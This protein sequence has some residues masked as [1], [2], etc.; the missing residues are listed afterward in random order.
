MSFIDFLD[1]NCKRKTLE[2]HRHSGSIES[3]KFYRPLMRLTTRAA[4]KMIIRWTFHVKGDEKSRRFAMWRFGAEGRISMTR[5]YASMLLM[6]LLH[7]KK[8]LPEF[9]YASQYSAP[10]KN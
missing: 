3:S 1:E 5:L 8:S 7:G 2:K 4:L 6:F 10:E 9:C